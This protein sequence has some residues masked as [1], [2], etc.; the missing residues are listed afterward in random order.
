MWRTTIWDGGEGDVEKNYYDRDNDT[1]TYIYF[2]TIR[3]VC[4]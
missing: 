4:I 1:Y 2:V 3:T